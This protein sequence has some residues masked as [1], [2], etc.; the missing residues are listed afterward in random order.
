ME[1]GD[2]EE[3]VSIAHAQDKMLRVEFFPSRGIWEVRF[4][5]GEALANV[6]RTLDQIHWAEGDGSWGMSGHPK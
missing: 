3:L 4:G 6:N 2:F 5:F 1:I